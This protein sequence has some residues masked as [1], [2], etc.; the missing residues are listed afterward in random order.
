[1]KFS[2][3]K[4]RVTHQ[5]I[6]LFLIALVIG[7]GCRSSCKD[8]KFNRP[9][10]FTPIGM[11]I[12]YTDVCV[13]GCSATESE[14]APHTLTKAKFEDFVY[15]DISLDEAVQTALANSTVMRDLGARVLTAPQGSAT[16]YDP[17]LTQINPG[18]GEEA[19]L[20]AFDAQWATGVIFNRSERS[21]NNRF[22]GLGANSAGNNNAAFQMEVSKIAAAGTSVALRNVVDYNRTNQNPGVVNNLLDNSTYDVVYEAEFRHPLLKGG[23]LA[24]NRIAGPNAGPGSYR[25]II[26]ARIN[27]DIALADF[28]ANVRDFVRN[29]YNTYWELYFAYQDLDAKKAGLAA[30]RESWRTAKV[31]FESGAADAV[32]QAVAETQ[33]Y[34]FERQVQNALSGSGAAGGILTQERNLRLLLGTEINDGQLLRPSDEPT[35]AETTFDWYESLCN[36]LSRRVEIR[37]QKWNVKANEYQLLAARNQLMPQLDLLGQYR[38]RGFQS[39]LLGRNDSAY[40]NLLSGDLQG[41]QMGVQMSTPIGNRIGHVAVRHAE[42]D[43]AR[44]RAL[45]KEQHKYLVKELSDSF[46]E[47]SRTYEGTRTLANELTASIEQAR[48]RQS[49]YEAGTEI[50]QFLVQ[51]QSD[52]A[53]TRSNLVRSLVDYNVAISDLHFNRGTLLDFLGVELAE[54][55]WSQASFD[56]ARKEAR[57][58]Q[59]RDVNYCYTVPCPVSRGPYQQQVLPRGETVA[60]IVMPQSNQPMVDSVEV[61][62]VPTGEAHAPAEFDG[63]NELGI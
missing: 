22:L 21:F 63:I 43:L 60:P 5:A 33:Y 36:G 1:M 46:G 61:S 50:L 45:L 56:A 48:L 49:R 44:N 18:F 9:T 27:T 52:V 6:S 29:V 26:I 25:G 39:N 32:D 58:F 47:L 8:I 14:L 35:R 11:Q 12:E 4:L 2:I 57:R 41:W 15:R 17:A 30:A 62:P 55:G 51:A 34:N 7:T 31:R 3:R 42:L 19:A 13:E 37:R 59:K 53:A 20:S 54:G 24:F 23:G 16:I 28:E 40:D 10:D 38:W